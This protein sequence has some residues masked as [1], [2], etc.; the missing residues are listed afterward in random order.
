MVEGRNVTDGSLTWC[1]WGA[2]KGTDDDQPDGQIATATV[3]MIEQLG[4]IRALQ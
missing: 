4:I 1:A 2:A 3:A